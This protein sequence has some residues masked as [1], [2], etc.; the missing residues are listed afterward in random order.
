MTYYNKSLRDV[1]SENWEEL[2][3]K[4]NDLRIDETVDIKPA[5]PFLLWIENERQYEQS[6]IKVMIIG[7]ETNGWHEKEEVSIESLQKLYSGFYFGGDCW[8]YGG[9]FWNGFKRLKNSL[10][11]RF[12]D[13][14]IELV[15]NNLVKIGKKKDK[16]F[17]PDYIYEIEREYFNVL[18]KELDILKPNLIV[19]FSGPNYDHIIEEKFGKLSYNVCSLFD[20]R[21]LAKIDFP[22]TNFC[23][24]TY[25]PNYLFRNNIDDFIESI[26]E[27]IQ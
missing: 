14:K 27:H 24:R 18:Q 26:T 8:S 25:H 1:Y 9:Q 2:D 13:K 5:N 11:D 22:N 19:F 4:L 17:P 6:D 7:Q 3:R 16:G 20:T 15:W 21:R 12:P 10:V 23:F